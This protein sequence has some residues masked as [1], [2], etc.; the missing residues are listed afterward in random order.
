MIRAIVFD[1]DGVIVDSMSSIALGIQATARHFGVDISPEKIVDTYFQPR[2][3]FYASVG[4]DPAHG[5]EL[6]AVHKIQ[7]E[8]FRPESPVVFGDVLPVLE[9][10]RSRGIPLGVATQ[11]E[12]GAIVSEIALLKLEH[13]FVPEAVLGG[14]DSKKEKLERIAGVLG[15][16]TAEMLF[17]GDLPSDITAGKEAGSQTLGIARGGLGRERLEKANP[18]YMFSSFSGLLEIL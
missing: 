11:K 9:E 18:D 3:A 13:F 8:K 6:H 16:K 15:C 4:V 17:V 14:H 10:L 2:E 5:E 12:G 1:W 7:I